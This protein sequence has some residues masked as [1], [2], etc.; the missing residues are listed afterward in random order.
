MRQKDEKNFAELLNHLRTGAHT[1]KD[2]KSLN[3]T[4]IIN[5]DL[6]SD[7]T[8]PH[9]FPTKEQVKLHNAQ[10]INNTKFTIDSKA[11]D[12][13]PSSISK[14]LQ[15]N[16]HIAISKR[17]ES[18]TGG[19]PEIIT[20]NTEQQYDIISN[21]DVTDGLINGAECCIKYIQTKKDQQQNIIPITVWVQFENEQIGKNH[22]NKN[23][24][25]YSNIKIHHNW[26]PINKIKR[27]FLVKDI[28]I[29]RI[30]FPLRQAAARTIHVSQSSTYKKIYVD[31]KTYSNPPKMWWE[32]MHYVALSRVTN[33]AGIYINDLNESQ[34]CVS[35][36]VS[37]YLLDANKNHK[38]QTN[39]QLFQKDKLNIL[40]NN[41]RS[42]KKY[43][44]I[45]KND[46]IILK[47]QINIFFESK[48][49]KFD[50]N[51]NYVIPNFIIVRADQKKT[52][53]PHHG[54]IA[55]IY[56][57]IKINRIEYMSRETIDSLLINIEYNAKDI[58]LVSVYNSPQ[59]K[60]IE[61]EKHIIQIIEKEQI[62]AKNII[63][64]GDFNIQISSPQYVQLS[65]KLLKYNMKQNIS[66]YSTIYK[67]T[68]DYIFSTIDIYNIQNL[69]AHWSDH[70][71]IHFEIS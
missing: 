44:H 35:K 60:Y 38:L 41:A 57:D 50:Q 12:I 32:H 14:I 64:L 40:F 37:H 13:L 9:F 8:I 25:L 71:I 34:I 54:I 33:Y 53:N 17:Q 43:F 69:H 7:T 19:L 26:T 18:Q 3:L 21:I 66:N 36:K 61:F 52:I 47:Q 23:S 48:L 56:K 49:C 11:L 42:F 46:K 51:A 63:L 70:N 29:H 31:L 4:K 59:N 24:Y 58:T 15:N 2:I 22:R 5:K 55:Y 39:I 1:K 67:T 6:A 10:I 27:S 16:I 65:K 62:N 30:Q 45:A 28:W 20:L 68:I